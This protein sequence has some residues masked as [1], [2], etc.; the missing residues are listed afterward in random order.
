M[1][2][3]ILPIVLAGLAGWAFGA[4]WYSIF[5]KPWIAASGVATDDTGRPANRK[6]ALPY[7][8][9]IT[10]AMVVAATMYYA[11]DM[12][13]IVTVGKGFTSGLGIGACFAAPWLATNYGFAGRP[14]KLTLIDAGYAAFGSAA[15]GAVIPLF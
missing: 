2:M 3:P 11:F 10:S 5:A 8:I 6:T 7:V 1:D 15:I 12:L 4:A 9:S 13:N 14:F